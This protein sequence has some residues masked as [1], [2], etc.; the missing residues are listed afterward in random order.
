VDS[1]LL[2]PNPSLWTRFG[3]T[4]PTP[5]LLPGR[6]RREQSPAHPTAAPSCQLQNMASVRESWDSWRHC[7][8]RQLLRNSKESP[9]GARDRWV[10]TLPCNPFLVS[11]SLKAVAPNFAGAEAFCGS[12]TD[13]VCGACAQI[14]LSANTRKKTTGIVRPKRDL[15]ASP[16]ASLLRNELSQ[17]CLLELDGIRSPT[18]SPSSPTSAFASSEN[19]GLFPVS[20]K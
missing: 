11:D 2:I 16:I 14:V 1:I 20:S 18:S 19:Y 7:R 12:R 4:H 3:P 13:A 10:A 15:Q 6:D 8:L 17:T 9:R 5:C